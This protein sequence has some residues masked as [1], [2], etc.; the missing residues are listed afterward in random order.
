MS[1]LKIKKKLMLLKIK[2]TLIVLPPIS[3][4][5]K[6]QKIKS[7][8]N[9]FLTVNLLFKDVIKDLSRFSYLIQWV[10]VYLNLK[11]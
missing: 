7:K 10:N 4:Y 1:L 3:K 6:F 2:E 11:K 9:I 8:E 5:I